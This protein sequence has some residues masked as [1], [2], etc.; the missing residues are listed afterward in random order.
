MSI[1]LL[2]DSY[3]LTLMGRIVQFS[4]LVKLN[5]LILLIMLKYGV[6]SSDLFKKLFKVLE[7]T[8]FLL[9][10]LKFL[11]FLETTFFKVIEKTK[12]DNKGVQNQIL[13]LGVDIDIFKLETV[14]FT[15][16]VFIRYGMR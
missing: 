16:T 3:S 11:F 12:I 9:I 5:L 7:S 2:S 14:N 10:T 1:T 15:H 4:I 13:H 8:F 6:I